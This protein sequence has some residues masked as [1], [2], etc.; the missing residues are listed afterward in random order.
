M[1]RLGRL[2]VD[3]DIP[4]KTF[5]ICDQIFFGLLMLSLSTSLWW[6]DFAFL[7][8]LLHLF[9]K[10]LYDFQLSLD[11]DF[12]AFL[13]VWL[14][15]FINFLVSISSHGH[16]LPFT[17]FSIWDACVSKTSCKDT[18]GLNQN[19]LHHKQVTSQ[20]WLHLILVLQENNLYNFYILLF[21]NYSKCY[22]SFSSKRSY[23]DL[24]LSLEKH[25]CSLYFQGG[26]WLLN[27]L[28]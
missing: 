22:L 9:L 26:S 3:C 23:R 17:H 20:F 28:K 13:N 1:F 24:L 27:L 25:L 18:A 5:L 19:R 21:L 15:L 7:I 2:S 4:G 14:H 8:F 10:V 11:L 16:G 6:F 12:L